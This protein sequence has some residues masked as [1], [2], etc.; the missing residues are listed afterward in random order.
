MDDIILIGGGGHCKSC[1]EII[2]STGDFN[3]KGILDIEENVG[4]TV[5]GYPIIN[6]DDAIEEYQSD[7]KF[8]ITVGHI[9]SAKIRKT[10][11]NKVKSV[12]GKLATI[13]SP[14]AYLSKRSKIG[15]GTIIMNDVIINAHCKIGVNNIIN[16]KALLEHDVE[17][18]DHNHIS[19]NATINGTVLIG[20][21][22]MIGSSST[23]INNISIANNI[24]I[25]AGATV[26]NNISK[27]GSYVGIPAKRKN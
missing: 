23:L 1:I 19:T 25:G 3:I 15:E 8:L 26:V 24:I 4:K 27:E 20:C 2:E 10:I 13:I 11:Y 12:N 22:N 21:N 17:I 18:A 16:N 14:R 9:N 5:C 7:H 6:T